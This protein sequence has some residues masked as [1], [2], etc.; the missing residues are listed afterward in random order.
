MRDPRPGLPATSLLLFPL[1]LS[2]VGG[3]VPR[4]QYDA[5]EETLAHTRQT[6]EA[7]LAAC[8][9][10]MAVMTAS[11]GAEA[12]LAA[13]L[14]REMRQLQGA[15][16]EAR[17]DLAESAAERQKLTTDL[18]TVVRDRSRLR[19]SIEEM[20]RAL[21]E[22]AARKAAAD[23]RIAEFRN[24]VERFQSLIDAGRLHVRIIDGRMVVQ[25]ATD[26]LFGSGSA[27]LSDEGREAVQEVAGVLAELGGRRFQVEG[28]TDNVPI[29]TAQFPSNWQLASARS[30]T[31]VQAMVEAGVPVEN[32]SAASYGEHRPAADNDTPEG[33]AANRRIEIVLLPDLSSLPGFEELES[34]AA[35]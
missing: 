4:G 2:V 24:L 30:I 32:V 16:D 19:A 23:R 7:E 12:Q 17:R 13:E 20:E 9:E 35:D 31:V 21:S 26:V 5:L 3:C 28:H 15:L 1:L 18:A 22:L 8:R 33:R 29:Q 11:M 34:L 27:R 14:R 10:E 25:L 6:A